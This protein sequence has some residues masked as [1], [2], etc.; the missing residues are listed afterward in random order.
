MAVVA[1]GG[2]GRKISEQT[3]VCPGCGA[4]RSAVKRARPAKASVPP[5]NKRLDSA[6]EPSS[7]PSAAAP[8]GIAETADQARLL[9]DVVA[10]LRLLKKAVERSGGQDGQGVVVRDIQMGFLSMVVFMVKWAI[11]A[12]PALVILFFLFSVVVSFFTAFNGYGH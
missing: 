1:C 8:A 11:A 6:A 7:A 2:C 5:V 10:E 12:I 4:D 9:R 3:M